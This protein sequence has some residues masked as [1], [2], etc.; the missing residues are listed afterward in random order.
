MGEFVAFRAL[1]A[2]LK[3]TNQEHLLTETYARCQAENKKPAADIHNQVQ[4]LFEVFTQEE[5]STKIAEIVT[6]EEGV[7]PDVEV[8]YQTI[9]GLHR[10]CPEKTGDWYFSGNY[11]TAGG[12]RVVNKAFM[13]FFEG[14]N[15]RA[16]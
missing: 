11:P 14:K 16:Y 2:L 8:I 15:V 3:E 13:N 6:P 1:V 9:E 10:A 4:S 5:I 7:E 12:H